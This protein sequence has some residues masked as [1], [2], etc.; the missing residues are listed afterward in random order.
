MQ[1]E[2]PQTTTIAPAAKQNTQNPYILYI[3][4]DSSQNLK[5]LYRDSFT[6]PKYAPY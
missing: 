6:Q 2:Q 3:Q 5:G 4:L 1:E